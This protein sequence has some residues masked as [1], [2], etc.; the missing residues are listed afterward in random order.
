MQLADESLCSSTS[1]ADT[2]AHQ[3]TTISLNLTFS[4]LH[5]LCRW[6][7]GNTKHA[8]PSMHTTI[9]IAAKLTATPKLLFCNTT[10]VHLV[11]IV[12]HNIAGSVASISSH[13]H[14]HGVSMKTS[15]KALLCVLILCL[16][17]SDICHKQSCDTILGYRSK[18]LLDS[19]V[20]ECSIM[21]LLH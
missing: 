16:T 9:T 2:S 1:K 10:R 5:L 18:L 20:L 7:S 6:M 8:R 14:Q 12:H 13:I 21:R 17:G 15:R 11:D 4:G 19:P 3:I